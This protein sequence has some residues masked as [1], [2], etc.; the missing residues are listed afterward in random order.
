MKG[1]FLS[2]PMFPN[3][4]VHWKQIHKEH[5][6]LWKLDGV[7]GWFCSV[8]QKLKEFVSTVEAVQ[9][10]M[11]DHINTYGREIFYRDFLVYSK[12]LDSYSY[13]KSKW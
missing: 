2:H 3:T 5:V 6:Y 4:S 10:S 1:I 8:K 7:Q 9:T 12:S 11:M 13:I